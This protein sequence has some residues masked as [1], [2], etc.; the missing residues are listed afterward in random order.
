MIRRKESGTTMSRHEN[1]WLAGSFL[2]I[3]LTFAGGC[4][5]T[6]AALTDDNPAQVEPIAGSDRSQ[7]ILTEEGAH[8]VGIKTEPV[9]ISTARSGARHQ[10]VV[11]LDAVLYDKDGKTWTYTNPEPLTFV[12]QEVVIA[13]IEGDTAVLRSGPAPGT[14]V[15]TVGGAELLGAEYGVPGE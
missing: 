14:P 9:R 2:L 6:E 1:R 13:R 10:S 15:V 12:P 7:V 11:P 4:A 3:G 8:R 5:S